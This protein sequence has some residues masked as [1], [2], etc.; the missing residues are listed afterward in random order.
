[1]DK[2][3]LLPDELETKLNSLSGYRVNIRLASFFKSILIYQAN[4]REIQMWYKKLNEPETAFMLWD[5]RNRTLLDCANT[6]MQR[7]FSNFLMSIF[8]TREHLYAIRNAYYK[9]TVVI[10]ELKKVTLEK[11][12][13][14]GLA[15]FMHD[16]RNYVVHRGYPEISQQLTFD[17]I[18]TSN[19]I[20]FNK[21]ELLKYDGW[22]T[23]SKRYINDINI[24]VKLI[25]LHNCLIAADEVIIPVTADR[26]ALQGLSQLNET[27]RAI[28]KR[29]NPKL[30]VAGLLLTK[31]NG[32]ANL[33][34][35][36]KASLEKVAESMN[37]KIFDTS[38]RECIKVKEAQAQK[39][40]L[41]AYAPKCTAAEDYNRLADELIG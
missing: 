13:E 12:A 36:V 10:E 14:N 23:N 39:Q 41:I 18:N 28:K 19:D 27:I 7:L 35:E 24:R 22:S 34:R 2:E 38:V 9:D 31:Y 20:F 37:T 26:Y 21:E 33:S 30:T 32:R 11:L 29:Q 8:A 1:M 16:F 17:E 3:I 25:D 6:E 5:V 4:A 15:S 40:T